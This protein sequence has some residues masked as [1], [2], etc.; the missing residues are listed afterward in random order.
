M[1]YLEP[2][3]GAAVQLFKQFETG[4]W[5]AVHSL[6]RILLQGIDLNSSR[7]FNENSPVALMKWSLKFKNIIYLIIFDKML[8]H[9]FNNTTS[10]ESYHWLLKINL[11]SFIAT[12]S[13]L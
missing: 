10:E 3:E 13:A 11:F 12:D 9:I 7:L 2:P 1:F 4:W 5:Q 6:S 8:L